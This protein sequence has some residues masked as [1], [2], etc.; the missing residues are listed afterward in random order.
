MLASGPAVEI[1]NESESGGSSD[2]NLHTTAEQ[3]IAEIELGNLQEASAA[4]ET[5][6]RLRSI[7]G[8]PRITDDF[9]VAEAFLDSAKRHKGL[10]HEKSQSAARKAIVWAD[11]TSELLRRAEKERGPQ[12]HAL[13]SVDADGI[14]NAAV[15]ILVTERR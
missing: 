3:I 15:D 9:R 11:R 8:V 1:V 7:A 12:D 13:R 10:N 2:E 14:T 5:E 6:D 4:W